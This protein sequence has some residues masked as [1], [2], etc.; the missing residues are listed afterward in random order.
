[1]HDQ[2]QTKLNM[3]ERRTLWDGVKGG[4]FA[5]DVLFT[6]GHIIQA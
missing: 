1:M 2:A 6:N 3:A 4:L 5:L